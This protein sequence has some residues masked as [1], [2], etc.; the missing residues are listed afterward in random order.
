ML[1]IASIRLPV[2]LDVD[3]DPYEA[4]LE[5]ERGAMERVILLERLRRELEGNLIDAPEAAAVSLSAPLA[6]S[7]AEFRDGVA[8]LGVE[9]GCGDNML[10]LATEANWAIW[11][12]S[13]GL[14]GVPELQRALAA[15]PEL[16]EACRF[17]CA[18]APRPFV[19]RDVCEGEP[20]DV[21]TDGPIE[22]RALDDCLRCL[23]LEPRAWLGAV[24]RARAEAEDLATAASVAAR[25][26]EREPSRELF[27]LQSGGLV[28]AMR[29]VAASLGGVDVRWVGW[30]GGDVL[31]GRQQSRY[32]RLLQK[33]HGLVPV[34]LSA[35]ET[36]AFY[37]GYCNASL[38]PLLHWMTPFARFDSQRWFRAYVRANERYAEKVVHEAN[39]GDVVW[40]HDF[41]LF[42]VPKFVRQKAFEKFGRHGAL[43]IAW[44]LHVPFPSFEIF[45]ALPEC[46]DLLLGVL[47][48]D[49]IGFH[50]Y[51]YLRHFRSVLLRVTGHTSEMDYIEW[52]GHRTRLGV[53][54]IGVD[55]DGLAAALRTPECRDHL[56]RMRIEFLGKALVLSVERL[57][58][59]RGLPQKLAAI[60]RFLELARDQ[61]RP[62]P[63]AETGDE[64]PY[65]FRRDG[66]NAGAKADPKPALDFLQR[67][68]NGLRRAWEKNSTG[69]A[70][71]RLNIDGAA[72]VEDTVFLFVMVPGAKNAA[73]GGMEDEVLRSVA[74]INGEFATPAHV[75]VV[76]IHRAV[77]WPE[78]VAL[79]ARADVGLVT[80]LV[81][82]MNLVAKEFV[83]A[84]DYTVD[85]V[86]P[87]AVVLSETCGAA[88]EMFDALVVNPH[89][90]EAVARAI[91][92]ALELEPKERWDL[93]TPMRE[94][95]AA[96]DAVFWARS[97]LTTLT[98]RI[99]VSIARGDA[100]MHLMQKGQHVFAAA[101]DWTGVRAG[102][103]LVAVDGEALRGECLADVV[104]HIEAEARGE[105]ECVLAFVADETQR[106]RLSRAAE[107]VPPL[108][109]ADVAARFSAS[110]PGRKALFLDWDGT[111]V[112][113]FKRPEDARPTPQLNAILDKLDARCR[114]D[115]DVF[116]VSGRP[117]DFLSEHL[118]ARVNLTLVAEHGYLIR[119][120]RKRR[121]PRTATGAC[122][123]VLDEEHTP[124]G[125]QVGEPWNLLN[126]HAQVDWKPKVLAVMRLFARS[127][128]GANVEE[129]RSA[130]V[131]HFRQVDEEFGDFKAKELV[132][133]LW[134]TIANLPCTVARGNKIVE[135]ASLQVQKGLVVRV[136]LASAVP[137]Y[138]AVLCVGDDRTDEAMFQFAANIPEAAVRETVVTVKV[139][140]G[141]TLAD[142]AVRSPAHV[143]SFLELIVADDADGAAQSP[144]Y[145][146]DDAGA[147]AS[148][149]PAREY[150]P[151][152]D[153]PEPLQSR[154]RAASEPLQL[155]AAMRAE[156]LS[157]SMRAQ[158]SSDSC[159]TF[160]EV[161][162]DD[163]DDDTTET[164]SSPPPPVEPPTPCPSPATPLQ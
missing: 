132:H 108:P 6:V 66:A 46:K 29:G 60:K 53:F 43:R 56:D 9:L 28:A 127:T 32:A 119:R 63:S 123:P 106:P 81:D 18:E 138:S 67:M 57:D 125:A 52:D 115:L 19:S 102:M 48:A 116:V 128:P 162:D 112:E 16:R 152:D 59:S 54:P 111:L 34:F 145:Y 146:Y 84:K 70:A 92:T 131:W 142:Y 80:P 164:P 82:G 40:V 41:H 160:D 61:R 76:V 11:G 87:G 161:L 5:A 135:V 42:L 78:L 45:S 49:L 93:T 69:R 36:D 58:Y 30:P 24:E 113:F 13:Q 38:W 117:T 65:D 151:A 1:I 10:A 100:A 15:W 72:A 95:L 94:A 110:A 157:A 8:R 26:E 27:T 17:L 51:A 2:T 90:T 35:A 79:Y 83:V 71:K 150:S 4:A 114:D 98:G 3:D 104:A 12:D 25:A 159:P 153:A 22:A 122:V 149:K 62:Q 85:G 141:N 23:R 137:K 139:G 20:E 105:A 77:P 144:G 120:R 156:S 99:D 96:N 155:S 75:P 64:N 50:T 39:D 118:G 136:E 103:R 129:K 37:A 121:L 134:Q 133:T 101:N 74:A 55:R 7:L 126:P 14:V 47:G 147:D 21:C 89:N 154:F 148:P 109:F 143:R 97:L 124:G 91:F 88:Q 140:D 107:V 73:L 33:R 31:P 68:G 163:L 44:F 158:V 130:L 86:E